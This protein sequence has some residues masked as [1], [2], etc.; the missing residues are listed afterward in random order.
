MPSS[1]HQ[2]GNYPYIPRNGTETSLDGLPYVLDFANF[3]NHI[4]KDHFNDVKPVTVHRGDRV[5]LNFQLWDD[6]YILPFNTRLYNENVN[7]KI[8]NKECLVYDKETTTNWEGWGNVNFDSTNLPL[9]IYCVLISYE[10]SN[11]D[12]GPCN[13]ITYLTISK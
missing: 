11:S 10:G 2:Y 3:F 12:R 6:S 8:Y 7:V 9:G 13:K 1:N 5:K 4:K